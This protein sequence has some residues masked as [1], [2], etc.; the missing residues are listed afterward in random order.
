LYCG[1]APQLAQRAPARPQALRGAALEH[2][3]A[4]RHFKQAFA[5]P[6]LM[7]IL[8]AFI[9]VPLASSPAAWQQQGAADVLLVVSLWRNLLCAPMPRAGAVRAAAEAAAGGALAVRR[10]AGIPLDT[11][12]DVD[13]HD[14]LLA[15][16]DAAFAL[17]VREPGACRGWRL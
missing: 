7:R 11:P 17:N 9:A 12:P 13:A 16:L 6:D 14:K 8:V 3:G 10:L 2:L 15:A 4:L 1:T 5:D